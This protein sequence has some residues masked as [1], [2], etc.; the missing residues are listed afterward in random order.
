MPGLFPIFLE[1][2]PCAIDSSFQP[3]PELGTVFLAESK[4]FFTPLRLPCGEN[5][6]LNGGNEASGKVFDDFLIGVAMF[7]SNIIRPK[8]RQSIKSNQ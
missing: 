5:A 4:L 2:D 1:E 3:G 7:T 6:A 8:Q